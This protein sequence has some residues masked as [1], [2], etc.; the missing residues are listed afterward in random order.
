MSIAAGERIA[1][2]LRARALT[3]ERESAKPT[4]LV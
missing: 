3:A 4:A 2:G 1:G